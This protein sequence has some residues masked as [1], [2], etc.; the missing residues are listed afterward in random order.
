MP[1]TKSIPGSSPASRPTGPRAGDSSAAAPRPPRRWP[2]GPSFLAACGSDSGESGD[3]HARRRTADRPAARCGSRTGRCTWPTVSSPPSRPRPASPWTTR[4]TSTTTSSGS[5]RSR[6]R[7]R[8]SRTSAPTWRCR[9]QFMAV[10]LHQLG[11]L[12][13]ISDAGWSN[14]K[15]LRPDLLEA[16]VDPEPQVQRP[17]HV[18]H[19][20][21]GLQ[22]G[23]HRPG[24]QDDRRPVGSGVQ[25]P[26]QP[27]LRRAGRP[28]HDHAVAGQLGRGPHHRDASRRPSTW[29]AN[30]RTRARSAGSPATTTPT[31]SP[32]AISLSRRHIRVTSC[33]CRPTTRTCSS[34]SRS[35]AATD[36]RRHHGDPVHHAEPEG[37]RGVDQLRLRPRQLRQAGRVRPV[38]AGAVGYDRR[39]RQGRSRRWRRTR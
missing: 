7:C 21:P 6:S 36:V 23:G 5:P 39:A 3:D 4:K 30:R 34:S 14:K 33:S 24:H 27:V 10:R 28:R 29:S 8:A 16:S 2:S 25:G 9:P 1:P 38:R 37:R 15:N 26:G 18:R 35:R 32:R 17:V 31:T 13:E 19:G 22:P 11:W 20:R 12:N